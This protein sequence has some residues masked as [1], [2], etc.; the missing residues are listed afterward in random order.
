MTGIHLSAI[1]LPNETRSIVF[2]WG[3]SQGT[4][5][6]GLLKTSNKKDRLS[7]CPSYLF[8]DYIGWN[9]NINVG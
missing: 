8:V 9:P 1:T 7:A 3:K 4:I 6:T 2:G 5:K